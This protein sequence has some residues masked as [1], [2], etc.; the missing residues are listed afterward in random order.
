MSQYP[1]GAYDP[2]TSLVYF[3][4]M[5]DKIRLRAADQLPPDYHGNLGVGMDGRMC[6]YLHVEYEKLRHRV[7]A[8]PEDADETILEWCFTHGRRLDE[9][10]ILIWNSFAS[11][12]GWRDDDGASEFL[13]QIKV[14]SGLGDRD[15]ILTFFE[16]FEVDEK[17]KA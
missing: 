13:K 16:F 8:G 11:K 4:R 6:R 2:T 3:A 17:R 12:R 7:L 10:D 14:E 9:Q 1:R 5:L 15:D